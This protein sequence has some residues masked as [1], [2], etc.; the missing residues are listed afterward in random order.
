[1]CSSKIKKRKRCEI[2][3]KIIAPTAKRNQRNSQDE[4]HRAEIEN[5]Q[6]R[7]KQK[8]EIQGQPIWDDTGNKTAYIY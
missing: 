5:Y 4:D 3:Q 2:F 8:V 1:M 7:V 6:A